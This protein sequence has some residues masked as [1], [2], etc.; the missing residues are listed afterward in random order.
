MNIQFSESWLRTFIN[1]PI[2]SRELSN[3]LTMIGLEVEKISPISIFSE[4]IVTAS[5]FDIKPHPNSENLNIC[6]IYDGSQLL[7]VICSADNLKI[8]LIVPLAYVGSELPNGKK[9][10]D[11][12]IR[13]IQSFGML[14]SPA[15]LG[16]S[17]E[18]PGV[19]E[20]SEDT[21]LGQPIHNVLNLDDKL[22]VLN[23]TPNRADCLSILGIAR[24][25]SALTEINIKIP[26]IKKIAPKTEDHVPVKIQAYDLCG[27]FSG[28]IIREINVNAAIP[29]II[30]ERLKQSGQKS[31]STL[32]DI[33]NY[34]MLERGCP[35]HIFDLD[36]INGEIVIRWAKKGE[37]L[38][39]SNGQRIEL[40]S[41]V[42]LISINDRAECIAGIME[43]RF[44]AVSLNT[45]NIYLNMPFL[46][47]N[48]VRGIARHYRLD[49][50]SSNRFERGVDYDSILEN[51]E[52]I[53]S[54]IIDICGGYVGPVD[55]YSVNIPSRPT[56]RM[57]LSRCQR[58]LGIPIKHS[59]VVKIFTKLGFQFKTLNEDFFV[60]PPSYRFDLN[61]EEELIEEVAR[62]YGFEKIPY[63][64]PLIKAEMLKK[65]SMK[66]ST[67]YWRHLLAAQDYQ[68]VINYS[69]VK[70]EWE[71]DYSNNDNPIRLLNPV[72]HQ[73]SV[74]RSSLI[75]GLIS[76][77]FYNSKRKQYRVRVFELGRVFMRDSEIKNNTLNV[78]GINQ[79]IRLAG[80]AWG[81][82]L[83]DQWGISNRPVDFY[84][85]KCDVEN[86]FGKYASRQLK[87]THKKHPALHSGRSACINLNEQT[88][89]WIGELDPRLSKKVGLIQSPIVFELD[90]ESLLKIGTPKLNKISKNPIVTRDLS[91][92]INKNIPVQEI[93]DTIRSLIKD[94][95]KLNIIQ[96]MFVYDVW[97]QESINNEG[98]I[99]EKSLTLRFYLQDFNKNL[100]EAFISNCITHIKNELIRIH[101]ARQR[102]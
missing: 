15:E 41:N 20:L 7:Q 68:E 52:Y 101:F 4:K 37:F 64:P 44:I 55:D 10:Q 62:I 34:A 61:I 43:S 30:K 31:I 36:K 35:A 71:Y 22:F 88:I 78:K 53:T 12:K 27:R 21:P 98:F 1:P 73:L 23:I 46:F 85:V 92:W 11:L 70:A 72:T 51:I 87:F 91:I 28:R 3:K 86:L 94:D 39:L 40:D 89:G 45:K 19:L 33:L 50:E 90:M 95:P 5:I 58:I 60:N 29:R 93:F 49:S 14:C 13:G 24:E 76:N 75:A 57:R 83:T 38:V 42:G 102:S 100:N 96:D 8:G 79:P 97:H 67:H 2:D 63:S 84:D 54:L 77:V 99:K 18:N 81:K 17:Q 80:V 6:K 82:F 59:E 47:P 9:I 74:M 32:V 48:A 25:V 16:F 56:V 26:K 65:S 69:F 66:S